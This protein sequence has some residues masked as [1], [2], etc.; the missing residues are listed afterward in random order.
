MA[1]RGLP[2]RDIVGKVKRGVAVNVHQEVVIPHSVQYIWGGSACVL[3]D[4]QDGVSVL[5]TAALANTRSTSVPP[6]RHTPACVFFVSTLAVATVRRHFHSL[7]FCNELFLPVLAQPTHYC[8]QDRTRVGSIVGLDTMLQNVSPV[9][10]EGS[11]SPHLKGALCTLH[12]SLYSLQLPTLPEGSPFHPLS[13]ARVKLAINQVHRN[14]ND[15]LPWVTGKR[16]VVVNP[17]RQQ[18]KRYYS[19]LYS[20][21]LRACCG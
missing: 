6:L 11:G 1:C 20:Y 16:T 12:P 13:Y 10:A 4:G 8:S 3:A 7:C 18:Q 21:W 15:S 19:C 17:S 14:G 5:C 9:K 2:K